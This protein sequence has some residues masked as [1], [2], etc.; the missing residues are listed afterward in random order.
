M[1]GSLKI[2]VQD[3]VPEFVQ[4]SKRGK[5]NLVLAHTMNAVE[6]F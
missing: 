5:G 6:N 3:I 2:T 1:A 4:L